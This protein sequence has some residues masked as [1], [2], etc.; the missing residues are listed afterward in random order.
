MN[1]SDFQLFAFIILVQFVQVFLILLLFFLLAFMDSRRLYLS[2]LNKVLPF[3]L[4]FD[5]PIGVDFSILKWYIPL[6][7]VDNSLNLIRFDM[8]PHQT[9]LI[10]N[11]KYMRTKINFDPK[12]EDPKSCII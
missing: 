12:F 6:F 10:C 9:F 8:L 3:M 5:S 11:S 1:L 4:K 2:V 7:L